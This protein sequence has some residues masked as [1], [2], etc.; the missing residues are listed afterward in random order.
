VAFSRD[1]PV[2]NAAVP[3]WTPALYTGT[4]DAKCAG[5]HQNQDSSDNFAHLEN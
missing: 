4:A 3:I 5:S 2:D 1:T